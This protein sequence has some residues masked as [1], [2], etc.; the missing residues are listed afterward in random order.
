MAEAFDPDKYL[1]EKVGQKQVAAPAAFDPDK[2]LAEKIGVKPAAPEEQSIMDKQIPI[3]GGTPRGYTKGALATLPTVGTIGGGILGSSAGPIGTVGGAALGAGA[4]ESLKNLGEK[5]LLGEDKS[6]EDIYA[7]PAKA[8]L[9]GATAEMG[10]QVLGA[11][12]KALAET[13]LGKKGLGLL[14]KAS[15]KIGE[16]LTGVPEKEIETYA[17]NADEIK[18]MAKASDNSTAEAADQMREKF[19][20]SIDKT[21]AD[22][23]SKISDTLKTNKSFV[24]ASK[25]EDALASAKKTINEKLYPEQIK[26]IDDLTKKVMSL[27]EDGKLSVQNANDVKK[28]LQDKATS[29][30][31]MPG[32]PFSLGTESAKAAKSG[33]AVAR[34]MVNEAAPE[35]A[36]AN[37]KLANLHDIEDVMNMNL[38]REGKPEAALMAAGSGGNLRNAKNLKMLGEATGTDMLGGAEKLAAMRT[39]GSPKLMVSDATGKS[40]ARI[41]V[42]AGLGYLV[43]HAPGAVIGT[44]ATSPMALR[45]AI[46]L[47]LL[48]GETLKNP[49]VQTVLGKAGVEAAKGLLGKKEQEK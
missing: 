40:G 33:A 31:R 49:Q 10:G 39:F 4:G 27:S 12:A 8:T 23:N 6:R 47:G 2:Y 14:G 35:I 25:I 20:S 9:E 7:G 43:G 3:I 34:Q 24:D 11:G 16:A 15:T 13:K 36:A 32:Q 5:Y 41:G 1:A 46:D 28:F 21:R 17:K 18:A 22:M 38:I 37:N 19:A 30:Y 42:G 48:T 29:A 26:E 44:A 45:S